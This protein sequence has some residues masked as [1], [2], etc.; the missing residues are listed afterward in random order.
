MERAT[1]SKAKPW[2]HQLPQA[3]VDRG[4]GD[5]RACPVVVCHPCKTRKPDKGFLHCC[6]FKPPNFHQ[7]KHAIP[8]IGST[9]KPTY[10]H[11]H[12]M[13]EG[14]GGLYKYVRMHCL[15][16]LI[17]LQ[18]FLW[19]YQATLLASLAQD[20]P[21]SMLPTHAALTWPAYCNLALERTCSSYEHPLRVREAARVAPIST[22]STAGKAEP[23]A[24]KRR[25]PI[26]PMAR[27]SNSRPSVSAATA[28]ILNADSPADLSHSTSPIKGVVKAGRSKPTGPEVFEDVLGKVPP[29][30][31]LTPLDEAFANGTI[32]VSS[33]DFHDFTF[34]NQ[35]AAAAPPA[36]QYGMDAVTDAV[37]KGFPKQ[38]T[39]SQPL[40]S[41]S[42]LLPSPPLLPAAEVASQV[43]SVQRHA[44]PAAASMLCLL[45]QACPVRH[46]LMRLRLRQ[47]PAPPAVTPIK[48]PALAPT[49]S[50]GG[51]VMGEPETP[52]P[53]LADPAMHAEVGP[54]EQPTPG[55]PMGSPM[56]WSKAFTLPKKAPGKGSTKGKG[57]AGSPPAKAASKL[58]S[59]IKFI[60]GSSTTAAKELEWQQHQAVPSHPHMH[61]PACQAEDPAAASASYVDVSSSTNRMPSFSGTSHIPIRKPGPS[62]AEDSKAALTKLASSRSIHSSSSALSRSQHRAGVAQPMTAAAEKGPSR[63]PF[64]KFGLQTGKTAPEGI[65]AKSFSLEHSRSILKRLA[66]KGK[67][68]AAAASS[69][70]LE[71]TPVFAHQPPLATSNKLGGATGAVSS[72]L[73]IRPV[74]EHSID[75]GHQPA[76]SLKAQPVSVLSSIRSSPVQRQLFASK[77]AVAVAAVNSNSHGDA[78]VEVRQDISGG[79]SG[80]GSTPSSSPKMGPALRPQQA[81]MS[82]VGPSAAMDS[83][84]HLGVTLSF[85]LSPRRGPLVLAPPKA[86]SLT[87]LGVA[88]TP[89][90]VLARAQPADPDEAMLQAPQKPQAISTPVFE[91]TRRFKQGKLDRGRARLVKKAGLDRTNMPLSTSQYV[92]CRKAPMQ[93]V[94]STACS[95]GGGSLL[96][97]TLQLL[98]LVICIE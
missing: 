88:V 4:V 51:A 25:Q 44:L 90:T 7:S 93:I 68:N 58:L 43:H 1:S 17:L 15:C 24:D 74:S 65:A 84:P 31:P 96:L 14:H 30:R 37:L 97:W 34:L 49:G 81:A 91:G 42:L 82:R 10:T 92:R 28:G 67:E 64:A 33:D 77:S 2:P 27:P 29:P 60:F 63:N 9:H 86:A 87:P 19:H 46:A 18:R 80:M 57:L 45:L 47:G 66:S 56:N 79:N 48:R 8:Y 54:S 75:S 40:Q 61:L 59:P 53:V 98:H 32:A 71:V 95:W 50:S 76:P 5:P 62:S 69:S 73:T 89:K 13:E 23:L 3:V 22:G 83:M 78:A 20:M 85:S 36:P 94:T 70:H 39:F 12:R 55:T 16:L 11:H 35:T 72:L 41:G 6:H 21:N 38:P 52:G 26:P